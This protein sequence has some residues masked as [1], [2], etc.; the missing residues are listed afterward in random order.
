MVMNKT[1]HIFAL[2]L[3]L[4]I[5]SGTSVA[6]PN[7]AQVV[8]GQVNIAQPDPNTLAITNSNGA[9]VNWQQ[10][11]I[12]QNE[13]TR[14]IQDSANSAILNRV[15]GQDPSSILGQ[16]LSNGRVFLINPNGIV[17]GPDSVI[18]TA[19]LVASTLDMTDEDFINQNLKFQGDNAADISNKGYIK[20]GAN[21]DIFLIAPNIENSGVIETQGGQIVLAAGESVTIAGLDSDHIVF[22]VQAP[23]NEVV[24]LGEMIT[25]GGAASMFAG[26]IKHSGSINANSIS[27]DK[28]GNV[29]LFAKADIEI[30]SDAIIT[31]NGASGGEVKVESEAGTVWHSGIIE[32]RGEADNGGHIE[33]LGERV[34]LLDNASVDASGETG[35][36]EILI[37]GDYQGKNPGVKNAS[38]T[39]VGEGTTIKADAISNGDGGKVIV[40]ADETA[41][42][43]GD[44][45]VRGGEQSGNGGFVETSGKQFLDITETPD[46][47]ATIGKAGTWL[48]DPD[49]ITI[50]SSADNNL[51]GASPFTHFSTGSSILSLTT[52]QGALNA[53]GAV[54]VDASSG[55]SISVL[56]AITKSA[57][58]D[59]TLSLL[60]DNDININADITSSSNKLNLILNA[61]QDTSGGGVINLQAILNGN[62]GTLDT[63]GDTVNIVGDTQI[64]NSWSSNS[65]VNV[66]AGNVLQFDTG[67]HIFNTGSGI[68]GA[69]DVAFVGG[70]TTF[71]NGSSYNLSG[72]TGISGGSGSTTIFHIDAIT[73]TFTHDAGNYGGGSTGSITTTGWMPTASAQLNDLKLIL[74]ANANN[75]VSFGAPI[76]LFG[77]ASIENQ[78]ILNLAIAAF[79]ETGTQ[80]F[81]NKGT[82]T[83]DSVSF[84]NLAF[85]NSGTLI[86]NGAG[87]TSFDG[88][89][90]M[91]GGNINVQSGT[92]GINGATTVS[93]VNSFANT[94]GTFNVNNLTI[95]PGARLELASGN[96][97]GSGSTMTVDGTL[98]L[99][100]GGYDGGN[101][102]G[103]INVNAGGKL[104]G[105]GTIGGYH[106]I[107]T[108][109]PVP[110]NVNFLGGGTLA[111][112]ASPGTLNIIGDLMLD[113]L[114]MTEIEI[115]STTLYD[116]IHVTGNATVDGTLDISLIN[117]FNGTVGD[118]F[119]IFQTTGTLSGDFVTAN[120][121]TTHT[122][123]NT[124][125]FPTSGTY[126]IEITSAPI[127]SS[128]SSDTDNTI[129]GINEIIVLND[130][131]DGLNSAFIEDE[132]EAD[133]KEK[134]ELACR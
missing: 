3:L 78:G 126:Q 38:Q 61:D 99:N 10:F 47:T 75:T 105:V 90:N 66:N 26:T 16:L 97:T 86:V 70:T 37:G 93:G 77:T 108:T 120:V 20:T 73:N 106:S 52:L 76:S 85:T 43:Y 55:G 80:S 32:A 65:T 81:I 89:V 79:I 104:A 111:P 94:G 103:T 92:L 100:G 109:I 71:N 31:A 110:V 119:D 56:N 53:G 17:F 87:I 42:I 2:V 113:P 15:I 5:A 35:G 117:G 44:I 124:P 8:N 122:F 125:N 129:D 11:S 50:S 6:N 96:I 69:G 88:P 127:P 9:I 19:G 39:Y 22:D 118:Q 83:T 123:S 107:L 33:V 74:A 68:T 40:W 21:G 25:N 101:L 112:G 59:A 84:N 1:N 132:S 54:I 67:T 36:G 91:N 34:A 24:N 4:G 72:D 82:L 131:Q 7:G 46:I 58:A 114:T 57:G 102:G 27:V 48:L 30:T 14:F 60:A 98:M 45:S 28:N 13:I 133:E 130:F 62:G 121:P 41:R 49:D 134:H 115:A 63:S 51:T 12:Q 116:N 95:N 29:Q 128:T 23:D 64:H 18:D